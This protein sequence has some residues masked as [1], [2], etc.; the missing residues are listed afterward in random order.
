MISKYFGSGMCV[1]FG[2]SAS[3]TELTQDLHSGTVKDESHC[4][5]ITHLFNDEIKSGLCM[6]L[7]LSVPLLGPKSSIVLG[8]LE[9]SKNG[10]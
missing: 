3:L 9:N 2:R 5:Q 4:A 8:D 1:D 6:K 7:N 10:I